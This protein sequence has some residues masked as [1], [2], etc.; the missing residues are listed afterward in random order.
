MKHFLFLTLYM[1]IIINMEY[2][3]N[4]R[5]VIFILVKKK[6]LKPITKVLDMFLKG[7]YFFRGTKANCASGVKC[8]KLAVKSFSC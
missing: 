8:K 1:G 4:C 6:N 7:K 3:C 2:Q 5:I